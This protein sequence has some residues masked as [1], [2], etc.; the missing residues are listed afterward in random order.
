M[1]NG[2][3]RTSPDSFLTKR[4]L[5][6]AVLL[7]CGCESGHVIEITITP[8]QAGPRE[9]RE[10]LVVNSLNEVAQSLG[11]VVEGPHRLPG[12]GV[13]FVAKYAGQEPTSGYFIDAQI[14]NCISIVLRSLSKQV[15]PA[16]AE[17]SLVLF[18]Q[19]FDKQGVAYKVRRN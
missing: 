5:A 7:L 1:N 12:N 6:V 2:L 15:D 14:D 11:M 19:I 13:S 3:P 8:S 17:R 18:E 9:Q 10:R 4:I 16:L